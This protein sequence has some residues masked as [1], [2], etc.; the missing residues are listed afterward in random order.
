MEPGDTVWWHPDTV[1]AVENQHHGDE[2][3]NVLYIAAVPDC[4]KN[5]QFL[6]KQKDAF[7]KGHSC[8]DF[9]PEHYELNYKGRPGVEHLT[10]LGKQQMGFA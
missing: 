5:Q 9:A 6:T 7:L 4:E 1:L 10:D 8:P 3:S 2:Y